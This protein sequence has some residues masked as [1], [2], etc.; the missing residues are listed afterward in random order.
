LPAQDSTST[1]FSSSTQRLPSHSAITLPPIEPSKGSVAGM[2]SFF[3]ALGILICS[4][5]GGFLF[6]QWEPEG[7]FILLCALNVGIVVICL[8]AM[9]HSTFFN[10]LQRS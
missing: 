6:D 9:I 4:Q 10:K 1:P 7:P 5:L 8:G 2:F 3:G